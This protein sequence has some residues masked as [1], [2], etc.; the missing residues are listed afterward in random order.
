MILLADRL[1][2]KMKEGQETF[3][4]LHVT[5]HRNYF[6]SQLG[7]F[8]ADLK[9]NGSIYEFND[10]RR[11]SLETKLIDELTY[12]AV[13]I[14]APVIVDI[15]EDVEVLATVRTNRISAEACECVGNENSIVAAR[16][17]NILVTSFHPELTK[18]SR[19][20]RYFNSICIEL[21]CRA[22]GNKTIKSDS[23]I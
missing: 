12:K 2:G 4:G 1:T 23:P 18:N 3:G 21:C 22:P 5:V 11:R 9:I 16:Q 19:W 20:H 7:S 13:F 17:G 10:I 15:S 8:S 6:G 14:R